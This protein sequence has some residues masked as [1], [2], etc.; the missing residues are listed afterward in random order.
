MAVSDVSE[1]ADA[2]KTLEND[3]DTFSHNALTFFEEH[4]DFRRAFAEVVRR[5]DALQ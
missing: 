2:I 5:V 4:L 3:Y 1:V